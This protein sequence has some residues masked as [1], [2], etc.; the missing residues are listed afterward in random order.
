V[1]ATQLGLAV[2]RG[3]DVAGVVEAAEVLAGAG[4]GA[5]EVTWTVRGPVADRVRAVLRSRARA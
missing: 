2:L 4:I 3:D 1:L 5:I